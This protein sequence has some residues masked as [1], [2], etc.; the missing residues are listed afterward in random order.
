MSFLLGNMIALKQPVSI[1]G[2]DFFQLID[3]WLNQTSKNRFF[4]D[5]LKFDYRFSIS[6]W[7]K[8]ALKNIYIVV[9]IF[10]F[11]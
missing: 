7:S 1:S 4:P 10:F 3:D 8:D 11:D 2:P 5:F 9:P 6:L